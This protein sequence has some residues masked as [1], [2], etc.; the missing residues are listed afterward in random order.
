GT[1]IAVGPLTGTLAP[2]AGRTVM[3]AVSPRTYPRPW[4]THSTLGG[5]FGPALKYAGYDAIVIRGQAATPVYLD[6]RDGE[7]ALRSAADLWGLGT[8][9]TQLTLRRR[10][11]DETQVLAIGPAGEHLVRFASVQHAEENA[12]AHSGFGAVWGAKRLK[13]IAVRGWGGV[14]VADPRGLLHEVLQAGT[15]R[16]TPYHGHLEPRERLREHGS[17]C[18]QACTFNCRTSVY[19]HTADGR[20]VPGTCLGGLVWLKGELMEATEYRGGPVYVPP[21]ANFPGRSVE[22]HEL[23]ND[24]GLDLWFRPV[25]QPWFIRCRQLGVDRIR[26]FALD[27]EDSGWFE[28]FMRDLAYRRGLGALF[29][30]DLRRAMD[31]LEG[32]LPRELV[33]LGRRLEFDFGFPAHREGRF[34]DEEPLPFWV[35]SA[36]MHASEGRDPTIG[37]HHSSLLLA[38]YILADPQRAR[39]RFRRLSEEIWGDADALEPT[40]ENKAPVAIWSQHQHL[41]IDSLPLCDFAFPQVVRPLSGLEEWQATDE[42]GGDLEIDRRLLAAVTGVAFTRQ[43]LERMAERGAALERAMLA[44][45]GRHRAMEEELADHFSL[46]CRADGTSIDQAGF[47]RLLD[48]YLT[49]RGW[50]LELGW[51]TAGLLARLDLAELIPDLEKLRAAHGAA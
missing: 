30:D 5:W 8:R 37:A 1:I 15:F 21:S 17:V 2:T 31:E 10:L 51:P 40:F 42:I 27:P 11:G 13:A 26:G 9:G 43:E 45:G 4:Y 46:P 49:A 41:L 7:A 50:D 16:V 38:D 33:D 19:G 18:S 47:S 22:Q 35:I 36:M 12:A 48:E 32:E 14:R 28:S 39:P 24:L 6:V 20:R 44:R 25:M 3:S 29:A 34:W 23:G